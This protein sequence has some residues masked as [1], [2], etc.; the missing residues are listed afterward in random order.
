MMVTPTSPRALL[1]SSCTVIGAGMGT[2]M[3]SMLLAV[4]HGVQRAQLGIATSLNQ[5]SRSIGAA[6]GVA[7]M[8]AVLARGLAGVDLPGG[9]EAIAAAGLTLSEPVR[10]QF[11]GA[12][13]RVFTMGAMVSAAGLVGALFLPPVAFGRGVAASAGEQML[14]AEMANLEPED[15]PVSVPD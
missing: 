12:L 13:H 1:I 2:Q 7:A 9:A 10:D 5:F 14:A 11:A 8:G 4:Q 6:V 3:L 15:E